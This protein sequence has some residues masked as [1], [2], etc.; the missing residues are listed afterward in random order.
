MYDERTLKSWQPALEHYTYVSEERSVIV[1]ELY[2][3]AFVVFQFPPW[4]SQKGGGNLM[5]Y[6]RVELAPSKECGS[7]DGGVSAAAFGRMWTAWRQDPYSY[8]PE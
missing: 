5:G 2:S 8:I 1:L 7:E 3:C 4:L 6:H